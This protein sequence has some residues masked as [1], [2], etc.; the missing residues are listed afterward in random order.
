VRIAVILDK[1]GTIIRAHRILCNVSNGS[2]ALC[3]STLRFAAESGETL[4]NVRGSIGNILKGNLR[5]VSLKVSC[6]PKGWRG[7]ISKKLLDQPGVIE[8][9]NKAVGRVVEDCGRGLGVC[10]GLLVDPEQRVTHA[11]ALGGEIYGDVLEA[12]TALRA[13][14]DDVFLATGNCRDFSIRCARSLGI[15]EDFVLYDADPGDKRELVVRLK[16]YYGSVIMVGNDLNDLVAMGEADLGIL[17]RRSDAPPGKD[18]EGR[19]EVDFIMDSLG[20]ICE[21]V[22]RIK[23]PLSRSTGPD[24]RDACGEGL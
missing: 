14:G 12:V 7:N 9:L 8:S 4:V 13:G 10:A 6:S 24:T 1:S 17:V 5:R 18:L 11:V 2:C 3:D 21:V 19:A 22:K 15:P 20:G 23:A 16:S